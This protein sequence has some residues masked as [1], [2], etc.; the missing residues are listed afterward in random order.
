MKKILVLALVLAMVCSLVP[1]AMADDFAP[2]TLQW[3]GIGTPPESDHPAITKIQEMFNVTLDMHSTPMADKEGYNL[4]FADNPDFDVM[5]LYMGSGDAREAFGTL[6]ENGMIRSYPVEW[7]Q[8]YMPTRMAMVEKYTGLT[9]EQIVEQC[10]YDGQLY[11]L[12]AASWVAAVPYGEMIRTDWLENLGLEMPTD[13]ESYLKVIRA[14]TF[15]DPDGNGIDD[16]YGLNGGHWVGFEYIWSQFGVFPR[17][18]TK[19]EDGTVV[20]GSA[21]EEYKEALK[22]LQQ[23]YVEGVLDPE[24]IT[25]SREKQR[26]KWAA[27]SLGICIDNIANGMWGIPDSVKAN[28]ETATWSYIP[29]DT[30]V[31]DY[32]DVMDSM[33]SGVFGY[34]ATD[35]EIIRIMQMLEGFAADRDLWRWAGYGEEGVDYTYENGVYTNLNP[36][37]RNAEQWLNYGPY[38]S[39]EDMTLAEGWEAGS[40]AIDMITNRVYRGNGFLAPT[41]N[42]SREWYG[43]DV[44][45]LATEY[46]AKALKGDVDIDATWD[47]YVASLNNA[48][49]QKILDEYNEMFK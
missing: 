26:A 8:E 28:V 4:L 49:L 31:S 35:E 38:D 37:R 1:T 16:T 17:S 6:Y 5:F 24:S 48:G 46:Y 36:D 27:G 42:E 10:S 33:T 7:L 43:T 9:F 2:L 47:E 12:P 3:Y 15:D 14:F 25:D 21:T 13:L 44:N 23:L 40:A 39:S 34:N 45:T 29:N 41:T 18:Y 19:Q 30:A 22:L 20:Y 11:G 32:L